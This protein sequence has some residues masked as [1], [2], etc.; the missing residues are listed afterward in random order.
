MWELLERHNTFKSCDAYF[1]WK[2]SSSSNTNQAR[3][4]FWQKVSG[5][6]QIILRRT[7]SP[8]ELSFGNKW[9]KKVKTFFAWKLERCDIGSR[10]HTWEH[11]EEWN[12]QNK[13]K[14]YSEIH[15]R[16]CFGGFNCQFLQKNSL[17][18]VEGWKTVS[19]SALPITLLAFW[20][21][22]HL[23]PTINKV[24]RSV[25]GLN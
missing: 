16:V 6:S 24:V 4:I 9:R 3:E 13:G 12:L 21:F 8:V 10:R 15:R 22:S 1:P 17:R 14:K 18:T 5:R 7:F 11:F 2:F 23:S 25:E 20:L 19:F